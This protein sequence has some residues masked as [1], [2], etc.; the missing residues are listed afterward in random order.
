MGWSGYTLNGIS[1]SV[2]AHGGER[3][4]RGER[5]YDELVAKIKEL[6]EDPYFND[7]SIK[8]YF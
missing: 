2:D 7:D 6:C 4:E 5:K 1:I 8:I 3:Q